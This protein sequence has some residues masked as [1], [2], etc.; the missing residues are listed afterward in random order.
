MPLHPPEIAIPVMRRALAQAQQIADVAL[1]SDV[2]LR[3]DDH[4][5]FMAMCF[6]YKQ[7]THAKS[8]SLLLDSFQHIDAATIARTMLEGL[9]LIAWS[10]LMPSE[11]PLRWRAYSLV[12][13]WKLLL[14]DE[15]NGKPAPQGKRAELSARLAEFSEFLTGGAKR[16]GTEH[17]PDPYQGTWRVDA[18]GAKVELKDM[19]VELGDPKIKLVYDELS[20]VGHWT[21]RGVAV[22]ISTGSDRTVIGFRNNNLAAMACGAAFQALSQTFLIFTK[23]RDGI[24]NSNMQRVIDDYIAELSD[25]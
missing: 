19:V 1:L 9:V 13:D 3:E 23:H 16:R 5:G 2:R 22:D 7:L 14:N 6:T 20:Q 8:V 4:L 18:S 12:S 11:R 24:S 17:F 21:P 15:C 25:A 10:A